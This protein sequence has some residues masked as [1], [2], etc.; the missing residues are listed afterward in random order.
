MTLRRFCLL[1]VGLTMSSLS[2]SKP[3][4]QSVWI[5]QQPIDI[6]PRINFSVENWM[7]KLFKPLN[8]KEKKTTSRCYREDVPTIDVN[9]YYEALCGGCMHFVLYEIY[10]AYQKLNKYIN[11]KLLPYGN[12]RMATD[13]TGHYIFDCQHGKA[14]C[15]NDVYQACLLDKVKDQ[16]VQ[17]DLVKCLMGSKDPS[18]KAKECMETSGVG[19]EP[20]F[21]V[22]EKCA[23]GEEGN[24]LM[25]ELGIATQSLKPAH[26][27][28]PW[29]TIN[30]EHSFDEETGG[31][32]AFLCSDLLKNAPECKQRTQMMST[33]PAMMCYREDAPT[34]S[35]LIQVY[36]EALCGGCI[37]F[38]TTQLHPAYMQFKKYLNVQFYPY[39]NTV[40]SG[41]LD[42]YGLHVFTCQHGIE[43]CVNNLFQACLFDKVIDT[44]LR[45]QLASCLMGSKDPHMKTK[46]C[47]QKFNVNNV[48][49][50]EIDECVSG[51]KGNDLMYKLSTETSALHPPHKYA[52]WVTIDDKH[53]ADA[54]DDLKGFL[55]K[56]PLKD[57]AECKK[58]GVSDPTIQLL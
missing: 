8:V 26:E 54:E 40:T 3:Q 37:E 15:L 43:E 44:T 17:L 24:K 22:I 4:E 42:P 35:T 52:P 48:S 23:N 39:G 30:G 46:E 19:P 57:V 5:F 47:M 41:N 16:K 21:D 9:L 27:Y 32:E 14:E 56:G 33:A 7:N 18:S 28:T 49:F 45:V 25:Y 58:N 29:V 20:S 2:M 51:K 12:T 11:L 1:L 31:L 6:D 36:Y 38:I 50:E 55:C 13:N 53:S 10:P 34:T